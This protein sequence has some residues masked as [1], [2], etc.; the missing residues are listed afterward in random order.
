[1][2]DCI[3]TG[4]RVYLSDYDV[5][6]PA[7]LFHVAPDTYVF[8]FNMNPFYDRS[9]PIP[10]TDITHSVNLGA[11]ELRHYWNKEKGILVAAGDL[12]TVL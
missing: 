6:L 5:V 4:A 10:M 2:T 7:D 11:S 3:K 12:V 9:I 8:S 1:M